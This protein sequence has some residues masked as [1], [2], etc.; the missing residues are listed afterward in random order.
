MQLSALPDF[1]QR[2]KSK[3][4][5]LFISCHAGSV[6]GIRAYAMIETE[7]TTPKYRWAVLAVLW[8]AYTVIFVQRLSIGPLAPFL[9]SEMSLTNAQIGSLMSAASFGFVSSMLPAGWATDQIGIRRLLLIGEVTA[10]FFMLSMFWVPS[11]KAALIIMTVSGFGCGCLYPSTAK[12][13]IEW[14]PMRERA[15]VMGLKQTGVNIGGIA[16]AA[17]LPAVALVLGWRFGFLFIGILAIM[18]GILSFI[19]YK[20][21]LGQSASQPRTDPGERAKPIRGRLLLALFKTPDIWLVGLGSV[22]LA[23]VEFGVMAHLVLYLTEELAFPIVDA[24][25]LLALTQAGGILGKPGA[26]L[27][28]DYFLA[29]SRRRVFMLWSAIT[30]A[31]SMII[32]LWGQG[33]SWEFYPVLFVFGVAAI[34]WGGIH[35]T[36][37][38]ELAGAELAGTVLAVLGAVAYVGCILGP[39]LF[40]YIVDISK[41]YRL[42]WLILTILA[43]VSMIAIFFV[44]EERRRM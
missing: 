29:G 4:L 17:I 37:V 1:L 31:T 30:C 10:G 44:R 25:I 42:A 22:T 6:D 19:V 36:L 20:D 33:F 28:S 21:P 27:L 23:I 15:T 2:T 40:G 18:V 24:G 39:V 26:G 11:Y 41:S 14:F 5:T 12:G 43:A 34:G 35:L 3:N 9:K 16:S 13:V 38:A 32:T 8:V 7:E